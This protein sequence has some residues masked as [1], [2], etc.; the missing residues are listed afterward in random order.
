MALKLRRA[1]ERFI[2]QS[3]RAARFKRLLGS[4]EPTDTCGNEPKAFL[5]H[6]NVLDIDALTGFETPKPWH[7]RDVHEVTP[8]VPGS[9]S[10][11]RNSAVAF[12]F[13][14]IL[15]RANPCCDGADWLG[16]LTRRF[17]REV[18]RTLRLAH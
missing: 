6:A 7:L 14:P 17:T 4:V 2:P 18:I 11:A 10:V 13:A 9:G 3:T 16:R 15:H 8:D 1:E 12:F 5:I